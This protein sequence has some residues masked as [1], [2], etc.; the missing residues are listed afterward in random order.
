[1]NTKGL[2]EFIN[3]IY[4]AFYSRYYLHIADGTD[5]TLPSAIPSIIKALAP[6]SRIEVNESL[7]FLH[8][9][10]ILY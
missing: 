8:P 7:P 6:S 4:T 5:L 10:S 3:V 2:F 9:N 1:M